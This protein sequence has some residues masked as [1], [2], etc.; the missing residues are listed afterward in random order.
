MYRGPALPRGG[1]DPLLI[2]WS[3]SSFLAAWRLESR[4]RGGVGRYL[5][6]D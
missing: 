4:P 1:P 3:I 6:R 2:P 5:P